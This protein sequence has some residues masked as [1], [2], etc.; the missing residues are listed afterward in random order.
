[1]EREDTYAGGDL[2]PA[3][4]HG[5]AASAPVPSADIHT[6]HGDNVSLR[7]LVAAIRMSAAKG[8]CCSTIRLA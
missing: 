4:P 6:L 1:M 7:L 5:D 2:L 8:A 3:T